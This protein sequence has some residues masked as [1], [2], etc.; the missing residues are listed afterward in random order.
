MKKTESIS[1]GGNIF[2]IEEDAYALL[3]EYLDK[4]REHVGQ[5][6]DANEVMSDIEGSISEKIQEKISEQKQIIIKSDIEEIIAIMGTVEDFQLNFDDYEGKKTLEAKEQSAAKRLYRNIDNRLIAGVC[7][8]L[9]TYFALDVT[10]VRLV[11][12]VL[13]FFGN[14]IALP[15]YLVLWIITPA[16][17]TTSQKLEMEGS[18]L[19]LTSISQS[20]KIKSVSAKRNHSQGLERMVKILKEIFRYF[21]GFFLVLT[22]LLVIFGTTTGAGLTVQY[23]HDY[24]YWNDIPVGE[25]MS[26]TPFYPL[27]ISL[28][29]SFIIP[30]FIIMLIGAAMLF[31]KK[32]V[33]MSIIVAST[34]LWMIFGFSSVFLAIGSAVKV[35]DVINSSDRTKIETESFA[36]EE[37]ASLSASGKNLAVHVKQGEKFSVDAK[38]R[39]I[40][41]KNFSYMTES[42]VLTLRVDDR[43]ADSV[44]LDCHQYAVDV[45]VTT[46][47][48]KE[49]KI[50]QADL[51]LVDNYEEMSISANS[52]GLS[53]AGEIKKLDL[54][55]KN[56]SVQIKS[57]SESILLA[58]KGSRIDYQGDAQVINLQNI[59]D[60]DL[61]FSGKTGSLVA[62]LKSGSVLSA[63]NLETETATLNLSDDS[64]AGVYAT[65]TISGNISD[66]S[67]VCYVG[68][69]NV[70][71][72]ERDTAILNKLHKISSYEYMQRLNRHQEKENNK[73]YLYDG[74]SYFEIVDGGKDNY[75]AV[76]D[77]IR[78]VFAD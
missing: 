39:K 9:A 15:I 34:I 51:D 73:E 42:G 12:L 57:K 3:S 28:A 22:S 20:S 16:A 71:G 48:L 21:F 8:G 66:E 69:P 13:L 77:K 63:F 56:S 64:W 17:K 44:C 74:K 10:M 54:S 76:A 75:A 68:E 50:D 37:F 58:D 36:L 41:L 62:N 55:S 31:R 30:A 52:A 78:S 46:P 18:P 23:A 24:V 59:N 38:G 6:V 40:D 25:I 11:F 35:S 47:D 60:S 14:G 65:S 29:A 4:V 43:E 19:T 7:S 27:M 70:K 67:G 5:D 26:V 49:I 61:S 32:M 53:L 2:L 1:L 72:L 45:T 33:S